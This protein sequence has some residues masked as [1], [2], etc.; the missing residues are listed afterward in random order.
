[1]LAQR[2]D[3]ANHI[4][5][6]AYGFAQGESSGILAEKATLVDKATY[7]TTTLPSSLLF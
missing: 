7:L 5:T 1:M 6:L 2:Q 3:D 4:N